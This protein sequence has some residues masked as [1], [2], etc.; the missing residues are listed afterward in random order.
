M[1]CNIESSRL[2]R[3]SYILASNPQFENTQDIDSLDIT[4][5]DRV[6]LHQLQQCGISFKKLLSQFT[7]LGT[8]LNWWG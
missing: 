1:L 3:L 4:P 6:L 2:A 7:I 5:E 8:N